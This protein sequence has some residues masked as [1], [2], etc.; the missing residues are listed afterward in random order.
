MYI[1][2]RE[3]KRK[4][5]GKPMRR[6]QAI[7]GSC[8]VSVGQSQSTGSGFPCVRVGLGRAAYGCT[9][10]TSRALTRRAAMAFGHP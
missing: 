5:K 2:V 9:P 10:H 4:V 6:Y 3:T 1:R 8:D 7:W